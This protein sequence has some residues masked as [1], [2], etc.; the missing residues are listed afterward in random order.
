MRK[1][2]VFCL[3]II[4][5]G[6]A[7][8]ILGLVTNMGGDIAPPLQQA[9]SVVTP[10]PEIVNP[11]MDDILSK[12]AIIDDN[13]V[14]IVFK[15]GLIITADFNTINAKWSNKGL[16]LAVLGA[17]ENLPV[18]K[19]D[20]DKNLSAGDTVYIIGCVSGS[21]CLY[22]ARINEADVKLK[23]DK[24]LPIESGILLNDELNIVGIFIG[25]N[26][27]V[28]ISSCMPIIKSFIEK[29]SYE[30]PYLGFNCDEDMRVIEVNDE[31]PAYN[32]GLRLD[33]V[34]TEINGVR[35]VNVEQMREN[36][37]SYQVGDSCALK[38][39][40]NDVTLF[41]NCILGKAEN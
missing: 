24:S 32:A 35:A 7:G 10:Q 26:E 1:F 3:C 9:S 14:G 18:Q 11:K 31:G 40:R 30:S 6:A 33:D 22:S 2:W 21:L 13:N 17:K 25:K 16:R 41:I 12:A 20:N 8:I 37:M 28:R 29:G 5:A 34:V 39:I 36:L 27:A 4:L 38:V 23:I 15:K 19:L